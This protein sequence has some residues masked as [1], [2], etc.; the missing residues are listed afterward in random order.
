MTET[1]IRHGVFNTHTPNGRFRLAVVWT[2]AMALAM[3]ATISGYPLLT[4]TANAQAAAPSVV[5]AGAS[6]A[7]DGINVERKTDQ[8]ILY[9]RVGTQTV[10]PTNIYGAEVVVVGGK[11]STI[12]DRLVTGGG[13]TA[14]PVGGTVLSGHGASRQWL[15]NNARI[16][17]P[18]TLPS[19]V[20][21]VPTTATSTPKPATT[22]PP[23]QTPAP[24]PT[25]NVTVGSQSRLVDGVNTARGTNQLILYTRT[26]S[27][28]ATPTNVYGAEVVV[29][30][31]RVTSVSDRL[32]TNAGPT[33]IPDG[34][35]VL[36]G[37][38]VARE[39]LIA[40]AKVG[41]T[42]T[43]PTGFASTTPTTPVTTTPPPTTPA[44]TTPPPT[45]P[46]PTSPAPT[47]PS[48]T[49]IGLPENVSA[50]WVNMWE[51][52]ALGL[53][54]SNVLGTNNV[55]IAAMAQSA[56]AGTG[57]LRWSHPLQTVASMKADIAAYRAKGNNVLLGIGGASDGGITV[58]STTTTN[59]F[60]T[61]ISSL[62]GTYGFT[63]IDID[64]EPSGSAWS[65]ASLVS[66]VSQLKA[67]YGAKFV[68]GLTVG[69][70]GEHT[71]R[72]LALAKALGNNYDYWAPMLYDFPEAHD[73]RLTPVALDKV[74]QAVAGGVPAS[75]QILGFMCNAYYNT[76]T[77][78]VTVDAYNAVRKEFPT[79]RGAF[80]WESSIEA[81][82]NYNWSLTLG[83][84]VRQ[85]N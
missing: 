4:N 23:T 47:I 43:L 17:S 40:N 2:L 67:K 55:Y 58:N 42:V 19:T 78:P 63:G 83:T 81:A 10:T 70:Y 44:P 21:P 84:Q 16:G 50:M 6:R 79:I 85:G 54:P 75:K 48:G 7:V 71:A 1:K 30:G 39:W 32:V 25:K 8:L 28:T 64:L 72:W 76:S 69:M 12:N 49:L 15:I 9:T 59:Q 14:I 51:G 53:I 45:T 34:G 46:A 41:A 36:S 56:G 3:A 31:S 37:H 38:G 74:R 22:P 33:P 61:S 52:P 20:Q 11:V 26:G 82:H 35:S 77:V 18:V 5:V 68:V 29:V 80:I 13:P 24:A 66:A 27:Q 62:V 57:N 60:V 65:Q 73:S